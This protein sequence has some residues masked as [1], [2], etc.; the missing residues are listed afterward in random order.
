MVLGQGLWIVTAGSAI[1][2]SMATGIGRLLSG[3]L[4]GLPAFHLP[5]F[6]GILSLVA[7]VSTL[8]C[9]LPVRTAIGR[10]PLRALRSE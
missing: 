4:Y 7:F 8:A 1:G 5:T 6:V 3:F 2:L 9:Y 10:E